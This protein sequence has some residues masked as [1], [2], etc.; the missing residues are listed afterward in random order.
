MNKKM[1]IL[2]AG[3]ALLVGSV[4]IAQTTSSTDQSS[5]SSYQ[6]PN[7]NSNASNSS[8]TTPSASANDA[9]GS[10]SNTSATAGERG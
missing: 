9:N 3:A 6:A 10:A 2:G 7:A 4:A 5:N 8:A 1:M